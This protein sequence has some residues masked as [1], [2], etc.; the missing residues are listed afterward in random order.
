MI[1]FYLNL[2]LFWVKNA[3]IFAKFF[4]KNI[5]KIITSV[6]GFNFASVGELYVSVSTV[7]EKQGDSFARDS[8]FNPVTLLFWVVR[9]SDHI[10]CN[11]MKMQ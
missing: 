8:T 7:S 2:A 6:P 3:N 11:I 1:N 4:G 10:D 9:I 5:L